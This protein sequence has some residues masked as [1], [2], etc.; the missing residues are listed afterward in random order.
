LGVGWLI[1]L[2]GAENGNA[3]GGFLFGVM[4]KLINNTVQVF[5]ERVR[6]SP[7][8]VD[9]FSFKDDFNGTPKALRLTWLR[10]TT[11]KSFHENITRRC[12][13]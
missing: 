5:Q 4:E 10:C 1:T 3:F 7:R 13:L 2:K 8:V 12:L 9:S 11:I 6:L